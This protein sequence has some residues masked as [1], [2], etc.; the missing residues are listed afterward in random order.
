MRTLS[1]VAVWAVAA[2]VFFLAVACHTTKHLVEAPLPSV[3]LPIRWKIHF[4]KNITPE[5]RAAVR[6]AMED[7]S[8]A[9]TGQVQWEDKDEAPPL[10]WTGPE[11]TRDITV[12]KTQSWMPMTTYIDHSSVVPEG[13]VVVGVAVID[14]KFRGVI[15]IDD[16][17]TGDLVNNVTREENFRRVMIHE[18]GHHLGLQHKEPGIMAASMKDAKRCITSSDLR[19]FCAHNYGCMR[20]LLKPCD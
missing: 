9:T 12:T 19:Q 1:T 20:E 7:W 18:F 17:V 10:S 4:D 2:L 5:E 14:C 15:I 16:R 3:N 11:C 6:L 8:K 13:Q